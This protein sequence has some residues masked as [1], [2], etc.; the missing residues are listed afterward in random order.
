MNIILCGLPGAGKTHIGEL[1]AEKLSRTFLDIDEIIEHEYAKRSGKALS[2]RQI[3]KQRGGD[4]FRQMESLIIASLASKSLKNVVISLGGGALDTNANIEIIKTLGTLVYLKR[5]LNTLFQKINAQELPAYLD[6][7]DPLGS[8]KTLAMKR[9]SQFEEH[10]DIQVEGD[11]LTP[12]AIADQI[13][14]QIPKKIEI[15]ISPKPVHY[16]IVIQEG[17][18]EANALIKH[19]KA[20][21]SSLFVIITDPI[22]ENLHARKLSEFLKE[23]GFNVSLFAV[24]SGEDSK[25][26]EVKQTCENHILELGGGRDTCV[27]GMGGGVVTDLAGFVAS[28]Y[29]RGVSIILIPTSLLAMVDAAIGGKS[30]VNVPQ[31]KNLIGAINQPQAVL[32]DT[33]LLKTLPLD[34]IKNGIVEMIK[35]GLINNKEYF[36]FM[37][38]HVKNLLKLDLP[39][40]EKAI[41]DSINIKARIIEEDQTEQG[42]R[43][44]LNYGHTFAHAIEAATKYQ[45]SHGRAVAIGICAASYLSMQL[46]HMS[47]SD[48]HEICEIFNSYEINLTWKSPLNPDFLYELMKID[49]N[50]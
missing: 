6:P 47:Q 17:L 11:L 38:S 44:L 40:M 41:F 26:R 34:E 27:I 4:F 7:N 32:I 10:A 5:D 28:T 23:H 24:P 29:L 25:T 19:L 21:K 1:L 22:I 43:R 42:C 15:H 48:F 33:L 49:K 9:I 30:G 3:F 39:L 20:M 45:I 12:E 46:G 8:F 31:G 37:K 2:C 36:N 14:L 18:L 35:H 13:I 16:P 50:L